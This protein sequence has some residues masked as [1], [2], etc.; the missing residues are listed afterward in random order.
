MP[1]RLA[2]RQCVSQQASVVCCISILLGLGFIFMVVAGTQVRQDGALAMMWLL[3]ATYFLHTIGELFL[4][5]TG[6]SYVA[7]AAPLRHKSLLMGVWFISSFLAYTVG[8]KLAGH[9]DPLTIKDKQ[10][11]LQNLGI[12]FGG[13]YANFFFQFVF[14]SIGGGVLIILLTPLLRKL[15]RDPKD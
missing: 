4:S 8:G 1:F 14:L 12:D 2:V 13:G 9:A 3:F 15:M 5:P 11:P 6:L 7:R 10:F